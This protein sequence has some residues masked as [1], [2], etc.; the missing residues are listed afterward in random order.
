MGTKKYTLD[1]IEKAILSVLPVIPSPVLKKKIRF[2]VF[3][4]DQTKK[5]LKE[6]ER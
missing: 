2:L 6:K 3:V 5:A 4:W 1:E